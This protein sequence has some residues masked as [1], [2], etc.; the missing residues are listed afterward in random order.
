MNLRKVATCCFLTALAGAVTAAAQD[1]IVQPVDPARMT[2]LKGHVHP[3]A[4]ADNDQGPVDPAM[5]IRQ[6]T[7]LFKPAASIDAFLAEQQLPGSPNY[8]QWLTPEQFGDRFGLSAN[9]IA[10]VTAWLESQGLKVDNVARGRH[11][12]NFSGTADQAARTFRTRFHH[13]RVNGETHFANVDEPSI[14]AALEDVVGGFLGLDDFKL[15]SNIVR[16]Q[17]TSTKGVHTLVPDDLAAIYNIA[18]LYAAGIDGTGQKIA[19]IGDSSLDL[20]D[21]RAFR[22]Q[23]NLPA[24]DPMQILVGDDP[25]YNEDVVESNLD[26][27]W[28][29]AVARG[30]QILYVYGQSV[31]GAAQFAVDENVA[32]VL[33]LSF[34]ACEAYNRASFRAVAQQASAQG[35]TWLAASGDTGAAECDRFSAIPQAAKGFA[36]GFPA[37]I[38]E[39]TSVGGTQF[40][41]ANGKYWATTNNVQRRVRPGLHSRDRLERYAVGQRIQRRRRRRQHSLP[42]ALLADRPRCARRQSAR[43]PR[44]FPHRLRRPRG[45]PA[46]RLRR[47]LF[48][49]R[50]FGWR[51][52]LAGATRSP[53]TGNNSEGQFRR[54][55][56]VALPS[57]LVDTGFLEVPSEH[58]AECQ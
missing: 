8:H 39:I 47:P 27:E 3:N 25:G 32:P 29:G 49:G 42:Q 6:A 44:C 12:I 50:H 57:H 13:Y 4:L 9:D 55:E 24:S 2:A 52:L 23:F 37:S 43:R 53:I 51:A 26:I 45:L 38:P 22:K 33:S 15:R 40:D 48:G 17:Y 28:A 58:L 36:V 16:P 46:L 54:S 31:F 1:R 56:V 34:G 18:P 30:A 14:P 11:W 21:I 41:D 35:I 5:P 20:S 7:L 10:Q 19:I